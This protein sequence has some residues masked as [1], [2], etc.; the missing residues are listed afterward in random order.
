[1]TIYVAMLRGINV[2]GRNRLLME[3]L[4]SLVAAAGGSGVQTYIQSGNAVFTGRGSPT[5]LVKTLEARLEKALGTPVP[6]IVRTKRELDVVLTSNPFV[7]RGD[8]ERFL[9]VTFMG[10]TPKGA[11]VREALSRP[12]DGDEFEVV[13]RDV[14]LHCPNGYG[15]TKLTNAFF[16]KRLGS[17]ATTRNWK[18]V[19]ALAA[20][21]HG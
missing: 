17:P 8:D 7:K 13:G 19:A 10:A 11:D 15:R 16:E 9:H 12:A 20:L 14:Y 5:T 1:M 2:S 21:A 6:V 3:D 4:R 18:T